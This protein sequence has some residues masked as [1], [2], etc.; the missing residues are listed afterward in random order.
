MSW[1]KRF[2]D[3]FSGGDLDMEGWFDS[4][5]AER[6]ALGGPVN[7]TT[8]GQRIPMVFSD[9]VMQKRYD[10]GVCVE[11]GGEVA[12]CR[13]CGSEAPQLLFYNSAGQNVDM[14]TYLAEQCNLDKFRAHYTDMATR[15][16]WK[17]EDGEGAVEFLIREAYTTG[18]HDA[19]HREGRVRISGALLAEAAQAIEVLA[20]SQP[21][22]ESGA[23]WK[24]H[25]GS[26][27]GQFR[28]MLAKANKSNG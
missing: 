11:C 27:A 6:K 10:A 15:H 1:F 18:H 25:Y 12:P 21:D 5:E 7:T 16:G 4:M 28:K 3:Y 9:P 8:P 2:K 20:D 13:L 17:K 26:L 14:E 23:W 22:S 24:G 19:I